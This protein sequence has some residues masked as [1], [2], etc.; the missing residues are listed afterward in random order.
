[1]GIDVKA[2]GHGEHELDGIDVEEDGEE[3]GGV[4]P[5]GAGIVEAVAAEEAEV[6][7]PDDDEE[8]KQ[9]AKGKKPRSAAWN[10]S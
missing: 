3:E 10:W 5:E 7:H 6:R 1:M 8:K 4:D 2:A 9:R